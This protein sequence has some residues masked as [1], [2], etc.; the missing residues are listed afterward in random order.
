MDHVLG[1]TSA[2]ICQRDG[3]VDKANLKSAAFGHERSTRSAGTTFMEGNSQGTGRT[4]HA[5]IARIV[6]LETDKSGRAFRLLLP[7]S[8]D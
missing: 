8:K 5:L 1:S 4:G 6:R 3:T 7:S 2:P